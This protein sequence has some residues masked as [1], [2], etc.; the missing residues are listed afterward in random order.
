MIVSA[1]YVGPFPEV[2]CNGVTVKRG[3]VAKLRI[4]DGQALAGCWEPQQDAAATAAETMTTSAPDADVASP[5]K[6]GA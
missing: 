3:E 1:K 4:P 2:V 6:K 5:K